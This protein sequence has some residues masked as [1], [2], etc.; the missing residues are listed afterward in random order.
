MISFVWNVGIGKSVETKK[1]SLL[2]QEMG[3]QWELL[4]MS[5]GFFRGVM[6]IF[7]SLIVVSVPQLWK[8]KTQWIIYFRWVNGMV[9]KL[10]FR[11][12]SYI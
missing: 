12:L 10:Y 6:K 3:A 9:Y 7:Q 11:K 2:R 4:L 1:V 5:T 8:Y